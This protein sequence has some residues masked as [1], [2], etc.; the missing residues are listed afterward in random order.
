MVAT[1]SEWIEQGG[2]EYVLRTKRQEEAKSCSDFVEDFILKATEA[3]EG[4]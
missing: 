4:F 2:W 3:F 1:R